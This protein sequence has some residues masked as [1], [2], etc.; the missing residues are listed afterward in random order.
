M[1]WAVLFFLVQGGLLLSLLPL[2][3]AILYF[4]V[5]VGLCNQTNVSNIKRRMVPLGPFSPRKPIKHVCKLILF[6]MGNLFDT[7][8]NTI[9]NIETRYY[10]RI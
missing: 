1:V 3:I 6:M 5:E 8:K 10:V 7:I 2:C 9:R 4:K